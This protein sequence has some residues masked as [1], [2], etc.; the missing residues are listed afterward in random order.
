MWG[1]GAYKGADGHSGDL[2]DPTRRQENALAWAELTTRFN[3]DGLIAT[4]W[5]RYSTHMVQNEPIDAALD[6]LVL[7]G[8]IFH[9]GAPRRVG[10][11]PEGAAGGDRRR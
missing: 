9:D 10:L 4:A 7:L 11:R 2:P 8:V 5:S 6:T 3:F 1:A